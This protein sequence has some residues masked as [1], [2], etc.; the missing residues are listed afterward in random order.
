MAG[1]GEAHMRVEV[2][3]AEVAEW[4]GAEAMLRVDGDAVPDALTHGP[5]RRFLTEI[6]LVRG[7]PDFEPLE[8]PALLS[9]LYRAHEKMEHVPDGSERYVAVGV[10]ETVCLVVV[11]SATGEVRLADE[12]PWRDQDPVS[13]DA[14]SGDLSSFL[15]ALA[16]VRRVRVGYASAPERG[17]AVYERVVADALA[18][19]RAADPEIFAGTGFACVWSTWIPMWAL[20]WAL[21]PGTDAGLGYANGRELVA[22]IA[23]DAPVFGPESLPA[24]LTHEP[25]RAFLATAGF[26]RG[27]PGIRWLLTRDDDRLASLD[28]WF[29]PEDGTDDTDTRWADLRDE[30]VLGSWAHGTTVVVHRADGRILVTEADVD[31][32]PP[33][34]LS[35]DISTLVA[36]LWMLARALRATD[37]E[38][39]AGADWE[40]HYPST[41]R[42]VI[43]GA[44]LPVTDPAACTDPE[45][46]WPMLLDDGHLSIL[47]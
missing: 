33:L 26:P 14:L 23:A 9:D 21:V 28:A 38:E 36:V 45:S 44:L 47:G 42:A 2:T 31:D 4:F 20:P 18:A 13:T 24:D 1:K 11:D 19:I 5:T 12:R 46:G 10:M 7:E 6:G 3:A 17:L 40:T 8:R 43:I 30:I 29:P 34:V 32:W 41:S 16:H 15:Y 27:V 39:A 35:T 22:D 37:A 25:T